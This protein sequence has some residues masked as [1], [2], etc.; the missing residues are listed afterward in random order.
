MAQ[1]E[2]TGGGFIDSGDRQIIRKV[3]VA[4]EGQTPT[5]PDEEGGYQLTSYSATREAG[6]ISR[7]VAEYTQGGAG[8]ASYGYNDYGKRVEMTGGTREVPI[9]THDQF[10]TMTETEIAQVETRINN[11]ELDVWHTTSTDGDPFTEKQQMLYN[12]LRRKVE[13][14]LAPAV[15]GRVSE[16]ESNLP[17]LSPIAKVANPPELSTPGGTFWICTAITASPIGNRFEVTREYTLNYAGWDDVVVLY[18]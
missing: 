3:Y 5:I 11:P 6:G 16:F 7:A 8:S 17:D 14:V 13:Y 18:G 9:Q 10:S 1:F 4:T 12:F 15:V 2:T